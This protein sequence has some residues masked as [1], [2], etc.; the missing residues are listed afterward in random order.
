MVHDAAQ[1]GRIV[2][3]PLPLT[4]RTPV[5]EMRFIFPLLKYKYLSDAVRAPTA[6][7]TSDFRHEAVNG[8]AGVSPKSFAE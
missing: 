3:R 8:Q 1:Y 7:V 5:H 4:A 2:G 6:V